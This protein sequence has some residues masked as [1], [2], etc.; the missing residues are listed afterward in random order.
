MKTRLPNITILQRCPH[1]QKARQNAWPTAVQLHTQL[2]GSKEELEKTAT[3]F[4]ILLTGL[5][6]VAAIEKKKIAPLSL[7]IERCFALFAL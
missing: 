7:V 4:V 1:L 6:G 2:Y 5:L 3:A